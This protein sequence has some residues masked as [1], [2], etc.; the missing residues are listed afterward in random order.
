MKNLKKAFKPALL[1]TCLFGM[2]TANFSAS[3][4]EDNLHHGTACMT[5]NLAQ[6]A[7]FS[8]NKDGLTNNFTNDLFVICPIDL[9]RDEWDATPQLSVEVIMFMPP[10]YTSAFDGSTEGP[11]CLV[12]YGVPDTGTPPT[13][14]QNFLNNELLT[15]GTFSGDAIEGDVDT[16]SVSFTITN[17]GDN[18]HSHILCLVPEG[19]TIIQYSA[20]QL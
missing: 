6:G 20:E 10:G 13:D 8:W 19:G 7:L 11:R 1:A 16:D 3:A 2:A 5:A 14:D 4:A 18:A 17:T 12:R 9:D 15:V